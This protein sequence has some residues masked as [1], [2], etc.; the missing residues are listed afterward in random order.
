[1]ISPEAK[2][3]HR[4]GTDQIRVPYCGGLRQVVKGALDRIQNVFRERICRRQQI[5]GGH[6]AAE[7]R[8]LVADRVIRATD[9][10]VLV[11]PGYW[12]ESD[13][14]AGPRGRG[15]EFY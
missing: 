13:L 8:L 15:Q 12:T 11:R 4:R 10:L 6:I 9:K 5:A 1:Q 3:S 7:Q 14:T 2:R